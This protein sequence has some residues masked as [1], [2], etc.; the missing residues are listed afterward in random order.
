MTSQALEPSSV[1]C[2]GQFSRSVKGDSM[3]PISCNGNSIR[4]LS[5]FG[6]VSDRSRDIGDPLSSLVIAVS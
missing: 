3:S 4:R 2:L 5:L 6:T 1:P